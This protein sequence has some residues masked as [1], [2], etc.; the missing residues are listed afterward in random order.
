MNRRG[1]GFMG[2]KGRGALSL[3]RFME[4]PSERRHELDR[5]F[6]PRIRP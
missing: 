5:P 3:P 1:R 4:R 6:E 2:Y